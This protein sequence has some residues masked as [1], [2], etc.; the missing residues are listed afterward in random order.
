MEEALSPQV[1][2]LPLEGNRSPFPELRA[3]SASWLGWSSISSILHHLS[4]IPGPLLSSSSSS[5]ARPAGRMDGC[6]LLPGRNH[7]ANMLLCCLLLHGMFP[8]PQPPDQAS[9][10]SSGVLLPASFRHPPSFLPTAPSPSS[11]PHLLLGSTCLRTPFPINQDLICRKEKWLP[12]VSLSQNLQ[13]LF[14]LLHFWGLG[15]VQKEGRCFLCM[16]RSMLIITWII[17]PGQKKRKT[18]V[19]VT[20]HIP[21]IVLCWKKNV[22][23]PNIAAQKNVLICDIS[24]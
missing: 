11:S 14:C 16:H 22:L 10:P 2:F 17:K 5:L 20:K 21:A 18:L 19:W 12:R 15:V 8:T 6:S 7:E 3:A 23:F 13:T 1:S 24:K 9:P 4:C